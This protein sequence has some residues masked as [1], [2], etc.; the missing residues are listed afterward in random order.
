MPSDDTGPPS[1]QVVENPCV[2]L[3]VQPLGVIDGVVP[4][5]SF[6]FLVCGARNVKYVHEHISMSQ[7]IKELVAE[8][9]ALP[10]VTQRRTGDVKL[11]KK[12]H[13]RQYVRDIVIKILRAAACLP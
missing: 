6:P 2:D 11:V 13:Q 1:P 5:G 7:V 3:P 12:N 9:S 8:S 10:A 4:H